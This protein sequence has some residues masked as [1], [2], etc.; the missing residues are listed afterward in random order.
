MVTFWCIHSGLQC[1]SARCNK[2]PM[3]WIEISI[4]CCSSESVKKQNKNNSPA[5]E[6]VTLRNVF[7]ERKWKIKASRFCH[8]SCVSPVIKF[9]APLILSPLHVVTVSTACCTG[10]G[11]GKSIF[12][13]V[14][15]QSLKTTCSCM[16]TIDA[17]PT[18]SGS[19]SPWW[20]W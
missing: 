16:T 14:A 17:A 5:P 20:R 11:Q 19:R 6:D 1:G 10:E 13:K 2:H 18:C 8:V 7:S 9:S 3:K 15:W 12:I 4:L